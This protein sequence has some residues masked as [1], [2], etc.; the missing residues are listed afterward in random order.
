MWLLNTET[1]SLERFED[2]R[3]IYGK[4]AILSHTWDEEAVTFDLIHLDTAK[5]MKGYGK[6]A[7]TCRRAFEDGLNYAWVDT[8]CIDKRSS[9]ELSEAINS[10]YKWYYNARVCYAY[11]SD[12]DSEKVTSID[13]KIGDC[14]W[15]TRGWTLQEMIAPPALLFFDMNWNQLASRVDV[16]LQ[17]AKITN[18]DHEVLTDRGKIWKTSVATRMSWASRRSTTREEDTAYALLGIFDINMPL[19]YGE[20]PRAFQRLQEEI[21]RTWQRVDRSILAWDGDEGG[22][23]ADSP[24]R[25]PITSSRYSYRQ[26]AGRK[27]MS[28]STQRNETCE[29]S[30]QGLKITLYARPAPRQVEQPRAVQSELRHIDIGTDESDRLLVMLNCSYVD[31]DFDDALVAVYLH[32]R[33]WIKSAQRRPTEIERRAYAIYDIERDYSIV[34]AAKPHDFVLTTLTIAR[35]PISWPSDTVVVVVFHSLQCVITTTDPRCIY[36]PGLPGKTAISKRFPDRQGVMDLAIHCRGQEAKKIALRIKPFIRWERPHL[37]LDLEETET[38]HEI[39]RHEL[40]EGRRFSQCIGRQRVSGRAEVYFEAHDLV[41]LLEISEA[42]AS[43]DLT[44]GARD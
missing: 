19:L 5:S 8:C 13:G 11:L 40:A 28:W 35:Y 32:R 24:A 1:L 22:V 14:R 17:L 18:V 33:P 15:F 27:I 39:Y 3:Q 16:A 10:M 25:F 23:L 36:G 20:G 7:A 9:A 42:S 30:N 37:L 31:S 26:L 44:A 29:L 12:L 41:W 43:E 6:I 21:I 38:P 34:S 2:P 4:Y